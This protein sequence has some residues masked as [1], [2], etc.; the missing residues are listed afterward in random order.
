MPVVGVAMEG[1]A[2]CDGDIEEESLTQVGVGKGG[3]RLPRR[4]PEPI[5]KD[6]RKVGSL[7]KYSSGEAVSDRGNRTSKN[8]E[9]PFG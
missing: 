9:G 4:D 6:E 2:G 5:L 1:G 3:S 7:V 8:L